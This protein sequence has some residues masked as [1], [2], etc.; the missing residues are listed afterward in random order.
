[1]RLP[2]SLVAAVVVALVALVVAAGHATAHAAEV[3]QQQQQRLRSNV[4]AA[5]RGGVG[6]SVGVEGGAA[7][8]NENES[9]GEGGA[10][11]P[12]CASPLSTYFCAT[13]TISPY[14]I[15]QRQL[16]ACPGGAACNV[17]DPNAGQ[18]GVFTSTV[19]TV[20]LFCVG[21]FS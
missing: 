11:V 4:R 2:S 19:T 13:V 15:T 7:N 21:A 8:E 9:E 6:G 5:L 1:M 3:Q 12:T 16:C 10:S 18:G 14:E 17:R 20:R